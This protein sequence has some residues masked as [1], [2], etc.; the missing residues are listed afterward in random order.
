MRPREIRGYFRKTA[1]SSLR[2]FSVAVILDA[3]A[4][5]RKDCA[6][7]RTSGR[8]HGFFKFFSA[9]GAV[10]HGEKR[11][12]VIQQQG[13]SAVG[14]AHRAQKNHADRNTG[15]E[16][17]HKQQPKLCLNQKVDEKPERGA[18]DLDCQQKKKQF[19]TKIHTDPPFEFF[20]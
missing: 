5:Y 8:S 10:I 20:T 18:Y 3:G 1:Q 9:V 15:N 2:G 6:F 7:A 14:T 4:V 17:K 12:G 13:H 19:Q 16:Q 11:G